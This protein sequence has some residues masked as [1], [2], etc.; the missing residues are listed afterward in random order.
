MSSTWQCP[1][2]LW[3]IGDLRCDAFPRG[4]P[5]DIS[6]GKVD[7]RV[8]YPGDKGHQWRPATKADEEACEAAGLLPADT[9]RLP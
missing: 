4:I 6:H 5:G 3:Y 7:H 1:T 9:P 8:P 2:C